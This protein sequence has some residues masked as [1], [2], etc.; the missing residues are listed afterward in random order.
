MTNASPAQTE[1]RSA[2]WTPERRAKQAASI[3][4]WAPWAQSTGPRTKA[5]KRRASK[6]ATKHTPHKLMKSA[7]SAQRRYLTDVNRYLALKEKIR[8]NELLRKRHRS[9][10]KRGYKITI[11]LATAL[12]FMN[13][14]KNLDFSPPLPLKVN[15]NDD[16][17]T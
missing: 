5:G 2:R 15:A 11:Q 14:W 4:L 6:N 17:K 16:T 13:I 7:L 12:L 1:N 9:L 3:R 8:P 10:R